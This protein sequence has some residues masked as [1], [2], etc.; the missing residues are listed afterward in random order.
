L[1]WDTTVGNLMLVGAL[2][3]GLSSTVIRLAA[4]LGRCSTALACHA[5]VIDGLGNPALDAVGSMEHC[6]GVIRV[7]EHE[8]IDRLLR[9]LIAEIDR[10]QVGLAATGDVRVVLF[11]DGLSELRR[12]LDSIE[13]LT[14]LAMLDRILDAGPAVG[15]VSCITTDGTSGGSNA[16]AAERWVFHVDDT[17]TARAAGLRGAV[18]SDEH[19]GRL[20]IA[21]SGLEAQVASADRITARRSGR[22]AV[23]RPAVI[24]TLPVDVDPTTLPHS[25]VVA[26]TSRPIRHL[27]LGVSSD[28]LAPAVLAL[29]DG[30]H[31]FVG[32]SARAGKSSALDQLARAWSQI[33]GPGS[34]VRWG[35]LPAPELAERLEV[36]DGRSTLLVVDDADR[37]T[38]SDGMIAA[39]LEGTVPRVTIAAAARMEAVRSAYGHWT[40]E[41]TR[42]RCG[43]VLT[44]FGEI[45]GELLGVTLP[46]RMSIPPRPGLAW[47]IDGQGHRLVQ[48]AG[49]LPP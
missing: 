29:A 25:Q 2:G 43:L 33:D 46:R 44:S 35:D 41:I 27:V 9:R 4:A 37:V 6:G 24:A 21:S 12:S 13:R 14:S 17:A 23:S 36:D 49:R 39:V 45:D 32:G 20:R 18:V 28:D 42:S 1:R 19:P 3:S 26:T 15:V 47:L 30:D 40:R 11:V 48:V 38:D 5:Y 7:G 16:A 10:R 34:V 22:T 31:L 8:R